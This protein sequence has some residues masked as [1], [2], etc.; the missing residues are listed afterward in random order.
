[1][2]LQRPARQTIDG[3]VHPSPDL[4]SPHPPVE[5]SV[6][7]LSQHR[8]FSAPVDLQPQRHWWHGLLFPLF[9][10]SCLCSSFLVQSLPLGIG[11]VMVYSLIAWVR[12]LPSRF[13]FVLSFLSLAT[14]ILLLVVRQ[15]V[16]LASNFA[17]YSFLLLVTG[18][19]ALIVESR[20]K[21]KHKRSKM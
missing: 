8:T 20:V 21:P 3:F 15:N 10:V 18:T 19:V 6:T 12:R 13:S 5:P 2:I 11:A 16:D 1:M 9:L 7:S 17:T 14:V 4:S